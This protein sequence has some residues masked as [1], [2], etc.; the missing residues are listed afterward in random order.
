MANIFNCSPLPENHIRLL[1]IK[2]TENPPSYELYD[3][4]FNDNLR[5]RAISYAWGSD[6]LTHRIKC[7]GMIMN[8]TES[9]ADMFSSSAIC[10]LCVD[11]PLWVDL[12]CINQRDDPEKAAQV[13]MM[14]SLYSQ[15]EEVIV[16]LGAASD[17]SDSAMR[18]LNAWSANETFM[19][20]E[21]FIKLVLNRPDYFKAGL[22]LQGDPIYT[23]LG[24]LYCRGWFTRLWVFQEV[25]LAQRCRL[26]CGSTQIT[27]EQLV[28]VSRAMSRL[29][30]SSFPIGF[31]HHDAFHISLNTVNQMGFMKQAS[32][33]DEPLALAAWKHKGDTVTLA[34]LMK[35]A[36]D[37]GV[38]NPHD[39]VFGFIGLA[40]PEARKRISID[41]SDRSPT[42][43]SKTYLQCAK[44]C[45]QEDPSLSILFMLSGR[46][47]GLPLPSWCPNFNANQRRRVVCS[48]RS[49]A[50]ILKSVQLEDG[51]PK[52]WVEEEKDILFG[53]GY[54]IDHVEEI[55]SPIPISGVDGSDPEARKWRTVGNLDW[56]RRCQS[57]S[58]RTLGAG[59]EADVTYI[60]TLIGNN[61]IPGN[62]DTDLRRILDHTK[63]FWSEGS[64][65]AECKASA[66]GVEAAYNF[67]KE[68]CHA[69]E[70]RIFF[71]SKGGR[72]GVGPPGIQ[73]GDLICILHGA[74]PL[75]VLRREDDAN[76]PLQILGD[77]FVH[78]C[79][80]LDDMYEQVRSSYEVF[81]IG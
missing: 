13:R 5:F 76:E 55:I 68:L 78:G 46:P 63:Y 38:S 20:A 49:N 51:L 80:D 57:L 32:G 37:K 11:M 64:F 36:D 4:P 72:I 14:A 28:S 41:Y 42:G 81:E 9:V 31:P 62:E 29:G 65:N 1:S 59:V 54:Q 58:Q 66:G 48:A 19:S 71:S 30:I 2:S 26:F 70:D 56:E 69:C 10:G 61:T 35:F 7:N 73:P 6:K 39:R 18:Q 67:L 15:A 22:K 53:P 34:E 40:T 43:W 23:A 60:Q 45:I 21:S 24:A 8:V 16:W 3:A 33:N 50:G 44:A 74:K 52:A 27:L 79:M 77:A 12:V 47:K 17:D 25:V 75:Y